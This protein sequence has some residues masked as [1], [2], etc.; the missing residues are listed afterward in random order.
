MNSTSIAFPQVIENPEPLVFPHMGR[1]AD[2]AELSGLSQ[3]HI[4]R[5]I[6]CGRVKST[7]VGTRVLVNLDSLADYLREG[8]P[9]P[10]L[11]DAAYHIDP[12]KL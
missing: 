7:R 12:R 6:N 8:D 5:L 3:N 4:R 1:V 9:V 10:A 2:A 11:G